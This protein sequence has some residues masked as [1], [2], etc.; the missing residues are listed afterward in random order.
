MSK[1]LYYII[2]LVIFLSLEIVDIVL[3]K[4]TIDTITK[5]KE[6]GKI[7]SEEKRLIL[8]S[9]FK[10]TFCFLFVLAAIILT[11]VLYTKGL[12]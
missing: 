3:T 7:T 10:S 8:I 5:A 9:F 11:I 1:A 12:L 6:D 2:F 4:N